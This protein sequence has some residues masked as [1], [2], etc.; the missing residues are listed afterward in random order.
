MG[1]KEEF[2]DHQNKH[3]K[4]YKA[5]GGC[6]TLIVVIV[7]MILYGWGGYANPDLDEMLKDETTTRS[8]KVYSR[9]PR[10]L[11]CC[12]KHSGFGTAEMVRC[13]NPKTGEASSLTS[14]R[15]E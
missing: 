6:C 10:T 14:R 8:T 13:K 4:K 12:I 9:I 15:Q 11:E 1:K 3:G 2:Q 7:Y 5:G